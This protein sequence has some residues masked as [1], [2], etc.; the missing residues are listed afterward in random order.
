MASLRLG[1]SASRTD[2]R[3]PANRR[4]L[5]TVA[6]V[7]LV[8]VIGSVS[9]RLY[10]TGALLARA[11]E[12]AVYRVSGDA[13]ILLKIFDVPP[14]ARAV[15]KLE[16]LTSYTPKPD[17]VAL[18]LETAVDVATREVVGFVQPF[19]RRT[20]PISAAFDSTGRARCGLPD[21][22]G[23]QVTLCRFLAEAMARLHAANLVMGDVSDTNFLLGRNWLGRVTAISVIDCNSLQISL[24]TNLGHE[25]FTSGVATEAYTAPEVQSTDWSISPRTV[26]SDNFGL[27]VLCWLLLFNGSHPFAVASPR[28]VD[29]PPLGERIERRLFPFAPATPLP[30]GWTLL[31]LDPSLGV[32]PSDLREMFFRTFSAEDARDRPTADEWVRALRNWESKPAP[33]LRDLGAWK[34]LLANPIANAPAPILRWGGRGLLLLGILVSAILLP[35]F[36]DSFLPAPDSDAKQPSPLLSPSATPKSAR[37]RYVDRDVFPEDFWIPQPR[38]KD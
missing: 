16:L 4:E 5:G 29:V 27:A 6:K 24:R 31:T 26:F 21:Q 11:G 33:V 3:S 38:K 17:F 28:N 9:G 19:Y 32:L 8:E 7:V 13:T 22:L 20:V 37:T 1:C 18:P 35:V 15:R 25:V 14:S 36:Q 30:A 23:H 12:G 34:R 10:R 2:D